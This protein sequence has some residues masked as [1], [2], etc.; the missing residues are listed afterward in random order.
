MQPLARLIGRWRHGLTPWRRRE[1]AAA[2][3]PRPHTVTLWSERWQSGD[4]RLHALE[5]ALKET[6]VAVTRGGDYDR[7]DL[8]ARVGAAGAART[9]M[10]V[11]EHG[12]G[13]QLL[14]FR[15]WGRAS[16]T[17]VGLAVALAG[18][19]VGALHDGAWTAALTLLAGAAL[20]TLRVLEDAAAATGLML[21]ALAHEM[22]GEAHPGAVTA[23]GDGRSTTRG[24]NVSRRA[25]AAES[26]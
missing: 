25:T 26:G 24:R 20:A 23:A 4:E 12:H 10:V 21:H 1:W 2:A 9:R 6:G 11:E 3:N 7:W 5:T 15:V 19:A 17:P 14:R 18:L 13:R 16:M 8:E 22:A